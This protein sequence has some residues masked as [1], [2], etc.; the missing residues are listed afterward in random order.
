VDTETKNLLNFGI[1]E[2]PQETILVVDDNPV[3]LGVL[4]DYLKEYGFRILVSRDGEHG[5]ERAIY[6]RPDIILLDLVILSSDGVVEAHNAQGHMLGFEQLQQLV[7]AAPTTSATTM[8]DYL[9]QE[10]LAF[11]GGAEQ[12]DDLTLLVVRV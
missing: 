7:Q 5:L 3:N 9:K 8:L 1:N 6:S 10:V 12:H 2:Q 11:T 4:V